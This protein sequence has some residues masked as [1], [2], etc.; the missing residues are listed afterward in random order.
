MIDRAPLIL[1]TSTSRVQA[2]PD[3][4]RVG[5]DL[6]AR[7]A[8]REL[9]A[10]PVLRIL[11]G[12]VQREQLDGLLAEIRQI[13]ERTLVELVDL[14]EDEFSLSTASPPWKWDELWRVLLQFGNHMREHATQVRGT[15]SV[16]GR[17][18]TQPQ[19]MLAEAEVAW[20]VLLG[21]TVGLSDVDL[22]TEPPDGGWSMRRVL[23]HIRDAES[24]YLEAIRLARRNVEQERGDNA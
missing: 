7:R 4:L 15:R 19:R 22:D 3:K 2:G 10:I 17:P 24:N 23:E 20:G 11:G 8:V 13:R 6:A 14:T 16:V 12:P 1:Y 5:L 21:S 18:P 9:A